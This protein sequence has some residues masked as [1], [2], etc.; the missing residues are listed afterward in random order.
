MFVRI[1]LPLR[2]PIILCF[3]LLWQ[4]LLSPETHLPSV[5]LSVCRPAAGS[6]LQSPAF[7]KQPGSIVYPVESAERSREVVFSC[8]AQGSPP[9]TYR[10]V[11]SS[12]VDSLRPQPGWMPAGAND[13]IAPAKKRTGGV[14]T[15]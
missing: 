13:S 5:C 4:Q 11:T 7:S 1:Q 12:P 10:S 2:W 9:P 6:V 14:M 15:F 8:E 3:L